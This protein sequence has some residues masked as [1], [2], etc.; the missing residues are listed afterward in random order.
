MIKFQ[1]RTVLSLVISQ[2]LRQLLRLFQRFL[3]VTGCCATTCGRDVFVIALVFALTFLIDYWFR[4]CTFNQQRYYYFLDTYNTTSMKSFTEPYQLFDQSVIMSIPVDSRLLFKSKLFSSALQPIDINLEDIDFSDLSAL[5][6]DLGSLYS[7]QQA[8]HRIEG[9][10]NNLSIQSCQ[11]RVLESYIDANQTLF[12][13]KN[14]LVIRHGAK[15]FA[16]FEGEIRT[17]Q[18]QGAVFEKI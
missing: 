10:I 16:Y 14:G 5:T 3:L 15:Y 6:L 12:V 4:R 18:L 8:G 11:I 2:N 7:L 9:A 1:L 17:Q 13:Y